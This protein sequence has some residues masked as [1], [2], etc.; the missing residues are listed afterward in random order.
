[1]KINGVDIRKYNAVQM[2]VDFQS[3][4]IEVNTEWVEN[5]PIPQEFPTNIQYGTLTVTVLFRGRGRNDIQRKMSSFLSLMTKVCEIELDGY[6]GTYMGSM[7]TDSQEKTI[8]ADRYIL[9][10]Q[11][12]GYMTDDEIVNVYKG[13]TEA[14][15]ETVGTRDTPCIIEVV[16]LKNTEKYVISGFGSDIIL[17]NLKADAKIVI[18]GELGTVTELGRNKFSE[19]DMW[20][21]PVLKKERA[22]RIYFSSADCDVVIRYKPMYL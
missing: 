10:L 15:F 16:P 7:E 17:N 1:M 2:T 13:P 11:F 6:K 21:F 14:A 22:N 8:V 19:C 3:P 9:K 5:A 18:D 4:K 20:E 12:R